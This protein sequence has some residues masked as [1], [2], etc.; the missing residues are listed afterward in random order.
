M[1]DLDILWVDANDRLRSQL[2]HEQDVDVG[3]RKGDPKHVRECILDGL[4]HEEDFGATRLHAEAYVM[5]RGLQM[6]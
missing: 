2:V 6:A 1:A 4:S 3:A 5:M